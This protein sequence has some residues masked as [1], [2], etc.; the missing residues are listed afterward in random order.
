M[1]GAKSESSS[2]PLHNAVKAGELEL[3]RK[4]L[5]AG[6]DVEIRD[7]NGNTPLQMA[8][9]ESIIIEL[10][11]AGADHR[12]LKSPYG[13]SPL[14]DAIINGSSDEYIEALIDAGAYAN[15]YRTWGNPLHSA[16]RHD[17]S[18]KVIEMLLDA[19]AQTD[20]G[21]DEGLTPLHLAVTHS[22][23]EIITLLCGVTDTNITD[24]L[25]RTP[26]HFAITEDAPAEVVQEL[27]D[28][29]ASPFCE[30]FL[31][32]S[33][34]D[35]AIERALQPDVFASL[36]DKKH[37]SPEITIKH[38]IN[39]GKEPW[40][41]K[42]YCKAALYY[43]LHSGS[44]PIEIIEEINKFGQY[45]YRLRD[46][47]FD[48]SLKDS[49]VEIF[50]FALR[51]AAKNGASSDVIK[52]LIDS[53]AGISDID[54]DDNDVEGNSILHLAISSGNVE[55]FNALYDAGEEIDLNER[56][57]SGYTLLHLAAKSGSRESIKRLLQLGVEM[58]IGM[59]DGFTPLHCAASTN[60]I[61]AIEELLN[62]GASV[63]AGEKYGRTPMHYAA[64]HGS[65]EAIDFLILKGAKINS[66]EE[67]GKMTPLH[68]AVKSSHL[69][70]DCIFSL[71]RAGA[72][73]NAT[74]RFHSLGT[75]LS[76]AASRSHDTEILK[77]LL[78]AGAKVNV[79]DSTGNT[80]LL[81]ILN[82]SALT[83][84]SKT[85]YILTNT[86]ILLLRAGAD[87]NCTNHSGFSP[88]HIALS[89]E[90]SG[91]VI[92][93][94]LAAGANSNC[95][96]KQGSTPLHIAATKGRSDVIHF[97]I[98]S[99]GEV[100][101]KDHEDRAP[102]HYALNPE[103]IKAFISAGAAIDSI[104]KNG[105]TPLHEVASRGSADAIIT[106]LDAGADKSIPGKDGKLAIE[107]AKSNG[108]LKGTTVIEMLEKAKN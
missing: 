30:D 88:L 84:G 92:T 108:L 21:D 106:L 93:A 54:E 103:I 26:L 19:G 83:G 43:A 32:K 105:N 24:G 52:L 82:R 70:Y 42:S 91:E 94:L 50:N 79:T 3:V 56:D 73:V 40:I 1:S 10:L 4:L 59:S 97:L 76:V 49:R 101:A 107:L 66:G 53:G 72:H 99:G 11:K 31:H 75:P 20:T 16:V 100:N 37:Q 5:E 46:Q 28:Y 78:S 48:T 57:R 81:Q 64:R 104:D 23:W 17:H 14:F 38:L 18:R 25:Y 44:S 95:R 90:H 35:Y 96:N 2:P 9:D 77:A 98:M 62:A 80:P 7:T 15:E 74:A 33:P 29:G 41:V 65:L 47:I 68:E 71:M 13:N 89:Q 55:T 51:Y 86:V 22:H 87:V 27:I 61:G 85:R 12:E 63:N 8:Q 39:K 36:I 6:E 45:T 58:N 67:E 60:S 34:I 102:L 69:S